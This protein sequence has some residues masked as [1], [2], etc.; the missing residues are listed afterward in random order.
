MV[1]R[2][3]MEFKFIAALGKAGKKQNI[4]ISK[5]EGH[6]MLIQNFHLK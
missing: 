3:C 4:V 5:R 2:F 1:I 6:T